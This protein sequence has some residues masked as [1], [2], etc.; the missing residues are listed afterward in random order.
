MACGTFTVRFSLAKSADKIKG[1]LLEVYLEDDEVTIS[2]HFV[3]LSHTLTC[4]CC[5]YILL[6]MVALELEV[7]GDDS[8]Q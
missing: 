4:P 5:R 3:H 2:E 6:D 7:A 1:T 8:S